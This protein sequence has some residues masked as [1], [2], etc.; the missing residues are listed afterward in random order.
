MEKPPAGPQPL[1]ANNQGQCSLFYTTFKSFHFAEECY[2]FS[3]LQ[4]NDSLY[5]AEGSMF[6][7][8]QVPTH[9]GL[10]NPSKNQHDL[11]LQISIGFSQ[12]MAFHSDN[13]RDLNP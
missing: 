5:S 6:L 13:R 7:L 1:L 9:R 4:A 8:Q 2:A 11:A 3:I 12:P 10:L